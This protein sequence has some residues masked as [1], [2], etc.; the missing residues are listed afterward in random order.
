MVETVNQHC[1]E[2]GGASKGF[3][4]M[5]EKIMQMEVEAELTKQPFSQDASFG[6]Q[7]LS[8]E[9]K[10][11]QVET[12]LAALKEKLNGSATTSHNVETSEASK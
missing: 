12:E 6:N 5:E 2:R 1:I 7:P 11:H 9:N 10:K 8:D 4:R 3:A